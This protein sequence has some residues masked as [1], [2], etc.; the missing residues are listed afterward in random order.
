MLIAAL[1]GLKPT[2]SEM[3]MF[4]VL[5]FGIV[6]FVLA[7]LSIMTS[8]AGKFF[9]AAE[10]AKSA[11][12]GAPAPTVQKVRDISE[13]ENPEHAYV[14][15]A[16]VAAMMPELRDDNAE[17]VAVLAAAASVA[18]GEECTGVSFKSAPDM[19]YARQGRAE[20]FAGK[21]YVPVRVK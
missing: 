6:M 9:S 4:S 15:A 20:L 14:V 3:L 10:K 2:V 11:P 5:G 8:I 18:L 16:A 13:I 21:S 19:S 7:A 12:K 1:I 17:L